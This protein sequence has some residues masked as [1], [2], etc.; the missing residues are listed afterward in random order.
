MALG[1][2]KG[3]KADM[4]AEQLATL[5]TKKLVLALDLTSSQQ[6]DIMEINFA[7]AEMRKAKREELKTKKEKGELKK[8]TA[9]ERF[10]MANARLDAQIAHHQRM[11]EV[12]TEDQ[13]KTWKKL[14]MGKTHE[15][16]KENAGEGKKR[17]VFFVDF[18]SHN[19]AMGVVSFFDVSL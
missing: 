13:Y 8:L 3:V 1:W 18:R 16:Q 15:R 5:Q 17:I 2:E 11:K 12:L 14:S 10:E 9:D 6:K 4:T 19:L 7:Q